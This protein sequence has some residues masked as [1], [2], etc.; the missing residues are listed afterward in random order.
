MKLNQ[1]AVYRVDQTSSGKDLWRLPYDM[2]QKK[3]L[4][5]RIEFYRQQRIEKVSADDTAITIWNRRKDS[6]EVRNSRQLNT[7]DR[8]RDH[9]AQ[10]I[11]WQSFRFHLERENTMEKKRRLPMGL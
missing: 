2:V 10:T 5:I 1:Y 9:F 7:R 6:F 11:L 3:K 4:Q 8:I